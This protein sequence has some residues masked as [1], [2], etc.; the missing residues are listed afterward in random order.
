MKINV[1]QSN[2]FSGRLKENV[3]K[4]AEVLKSEQSKDALLTVFPANNISGN[5]LMDKLEYAD[6]HKELNTALQDCIALSEDHDAFIIGMP[7]PVQEKGLCNALVFIQNG[8][9]RAVISKKNLREEEHQYFVKGDGFQMVQFHGENIAIGFYEDLKDLTKLGHEK[10]DT[11]ICCASQVFD[12]TKPYKRFYKLQKTVEHLNVP[13][14][15][16]NRVGGEGSLLFSGGS[17]ALNAM[18]NVLMQ[19]PYFEEHQQTIDVQL[20]D[21]KPVPQKPEQI[22]LI[23]DALVMGIRDYFSKTGIKKAVL[24]LSGGIDSALVVALAVKALGKENVRGVLMPSEFSTSH[25]VS[26]SVQLAENLGI[27]YDVVSIKKAYDVMNELMVPVYGKSFDVT[28]ENL[29]ARLRGIILMA[30]SN[31]TGAGVLNTSNK[32]EIAVGYGTLYG[33]MCGA[34]AVIGDLYKTQVYEM[35]EWINREKEIIPRNIIEKAPS[36]ELRH[37]Q[38]D[39]D[40]LPDYDTLDEIL[41]LYI[42]EEMG[43]NEIVEEGFDNEL[44]ESIVKKV[45]FNEYKRRQ[46]APILKVS[47]RAFGIDR[48]MPLV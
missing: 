5:P 31:K 24:G 11:V 1:V 47:P 38:K 7:L 48:K 45:K 46:A 13:L 40:S 6:F 4:V 29:Q 16:V 43:A 12:Y 28:E 14:V 18:G 35:S 17:M 34:L 27:Q 36:A 23:H 30:V 9:I 44:V 19:F 22:Q 26:D 15:L 3:Q 2:F 37:D 41:R 20:L 21:D 42:E 8:A 32:S 25:S 39:C 10:P 33:D